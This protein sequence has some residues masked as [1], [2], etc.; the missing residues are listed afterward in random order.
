M[1]DAPQT[2]AHVARTTGLSAHVIRM[3]EKRYG[4]V[5]PV[6]TGTNR[7]LY[8]RDQVERLA[9]LSRLTQAGRTIGTIARLPTE[10]LRTLVRDEAQPVAAK[11]AADPV[12]TLLS[13]SIDAI[14]HLDASA[15]DTLLTRA[16]VT[17]GG[18]GMLQRVAAPLARQIG[19]LWRE[20][21]LT[22]AHEHFATA[23]LRAFLSRSIRASMLGGT[24]PIIVV[25]TPPNQLHEL[26]ALLASA[27]AAN[28]G[29][30]VI[31]LG[32][33]LPAAE[34]AV[35]ARQHNAQA[36][37][38]SLVYPED[39]AGLPDELVRLRQL[40][41][42]KTKILAGGRATPSYHEALAKVGALEAH[43]LAQLGEILD[44][45]R[46]PTA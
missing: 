20:G 4:A 11:S 19:D 32:P 22:A 16:E 36:V 31:Y 25:G 15:L 8:G 41:P 29:W 6:R 17:L 40:L 7:R 3:W 43:D 18:H 37:A 9:L 5:A 44:A 46:R 13:A 10:T 38:L 45:L 23:V 1:E 35:A 24:A 34:F 27:T 28:L 2:I 33:S 42:E 39:D 26:G 14:R 30:R 21:S 12:A